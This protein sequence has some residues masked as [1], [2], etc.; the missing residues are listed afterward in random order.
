VVQNFLDGT[1]EIV[2]F[3]YKD[4]EGGDGA[5]NFGVLNVGTE[6]QGLPALREQILNGITPEDVEAETGVP[7]LT[8][9]D[10]DGDSTTYEMTGSPG[11]DV[12][13][14]DVLESRI[15]D[16]VGFFLHSALVDTGSNSIYTIVAIRFGRIMEVHLTGA[17]D[18]RRI[19]IQPVVYTDD[20]VDTDPDAPGSDGLVGRVVLVR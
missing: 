12:G 5:G 7:E 8:F 2:L 6:D 10:A 14:T 1:T 3:P 17:P 19:R 4:D 11:A 9:V 16:V 20:G 15:G 13:L 18:Q